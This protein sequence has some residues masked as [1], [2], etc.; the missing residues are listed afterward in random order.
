MTKKF[1]I[2]SSNDA[3]ELDDYYWNQK[4]S[5]AAIPSMGQSK[6]SQEQ[7]NLWEGLF[8]P[9]DPSSSNLFGIQN[10]FV[11]DDKT[12]L[13]ENNIEDTSF[14]MPIEQ[15]LMNSVNISATTWKDF[16]S[17][18]SAANNELTTP[19]TPSSTKSSTRNRDTLHKNADHTK[20]ES[21]Y[22][23]KS[24][25]KLVATA[26]A[27]TISVDKESNNSVESHTAASDIT[28]H[29]DYARLKSEHRKLRKYFENADA[30]RYKTPSV[31]E[32]IKRLSRCEPVALDFYR[33]KQEKMCL[34]DTA[35]E[36]NDWDVVVTILLFFKTTLKN[37]IFRQCLLERPVAAR[38]Y[39]TYLRE[40]GENQELIDTLFGLGQIEEAAMLE[41]AIACRYQDPKKKLDALKNCLLSGFSAHP[42]LVNEKRHLQEWIALLETHTRSHH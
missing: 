37:S 35:L 29:L 12:M 9:I 40:S 23:P 1:S 14:S 2:G 8:S 18:E 20:K 30:N 11:G 42:N 25:S 10:D 41:F 32:T 22:S 33:S 28:V 4:S 13:T 15:Q 3:E 24:C 19:S 38:H 16:N 36:L 26:S 17:S 21:S 31:T 6:F 27:S 5:S 34:L 39:I 7:C